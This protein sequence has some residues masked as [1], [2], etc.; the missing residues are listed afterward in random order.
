MPVIYLEHPVHGTKVAT[1]DMEADFDEQ[2]G[3]KRYNPGTPSQAEEVAPDA[4]PVVR[5]GRRKMTEQSAEPEMA[6]EG[7]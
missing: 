1:L 6:N 3:W 2:N 4:A 5:R 7:A